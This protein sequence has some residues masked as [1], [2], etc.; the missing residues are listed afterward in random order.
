ML[1]KDPLVSDAYEDQPGIH[2]IYEGWRR[3]ADTYPGD[4]AL[5]SRAGYLTA[6]RT[7]AARERSSG[8]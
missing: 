1:I 6:R 8:V 2:E 5:I 3:V 4:R 7:A